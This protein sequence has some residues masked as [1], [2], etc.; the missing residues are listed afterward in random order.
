MNSDAFAR[1]TESHPTDSVQAKRVISNFGAVRFAEFQLP[2][3]T[4]VIV[5]VPEISWLIRS[6][7]IRCNLD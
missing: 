1:L 2:L 7:D 4:Q 5:G 3:V 6:V